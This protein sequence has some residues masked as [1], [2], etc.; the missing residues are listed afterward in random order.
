MLTVVVRASACLAAAAGIVLGAMSSGETAGAMAI[1]QCA[2]YGYAFDYRQMP[3]ARAQALRK[4]IGGA[5][6][7]VATMRR[8]CVAFAIDGRNACG[9][10]G[11]AVAP[12]LGQA[13]NVALRFCYK[14]GGH[15]C[16]IR[17]FACD[18]KG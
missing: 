1:G 16:V 18:A 17:A 11:Y 9:A 8:G 10:H 6:K 4:C 14:Y 15:D 3:A 13:Q 12:Q 7:V 5:C 2:A